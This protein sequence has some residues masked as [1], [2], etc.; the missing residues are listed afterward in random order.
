MKVLLSKQLKKLRME[1]G[2]TQEDLANHL[3]ITTQAVSK[4]ER[5]EGYPD[6]TL[7]PAIAS[8]YNVS[9]DDLL[10]VGAIEKEK[11]LNAY[12]K[13]EDELFRD[14]K[15]AE[16]VELWREAQK[17]FPNDLSVIYNLMYALSV[18]DENAN[19]DE[20]IACGERILNESTDQHLRGGA[21]QCLCHTYYYVKNDAESAMKYA[22]MAGFI[23]TWNLMPHVLEG[24]EAVKYCQKNVQRDFDDIRLNVCIMCQKG[25][26]APKDQ[27]KA[28]EFCIKCFDL[29]YP[30]GNCG[31]YHTR[32]REIYLDM[33]KK[34][35]ELNDAAKMFE[36]LEK[37]ADH[38]IKYDTQKDGMY[39]SFIVNK[40][41]YSPLYAY[42]DYTENDSGLL[43]KSLKGERFKQFE[44][45]PRMV[46]LIEKLT[47]AARF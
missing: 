27:I 40:V 4:W 15:S 5:E 10:G 41:D 30:D 28:L 44:T 25:G 32:Y 14:G 24:E 33:A 22:K 43:L 36:C 26:Y 6:I 18:T 29:L 31:F 46:K 16:R 11:K 2:N 47:P 1:K 42:K 37:S 39:T 19:A 17:E 38:A 23:T 45:D 12:N 34:Y 7:L 13:K 20:V 3:G 21:V 9:I 8:Y 35:S